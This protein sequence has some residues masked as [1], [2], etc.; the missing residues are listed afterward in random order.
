MK[1]TLKI[2]LSI[3]SILNMVYYFTFWFPEKYTWLIPTMDAYHFQLISLALLTTVQLIILIK[4]L[5]SFKYIEKSTKHNWTGLLVVFTSVSSLIFIW[6]KMGELEVKNN[7]LLTE[8][9]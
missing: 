6:K 3:P 2:L 5:W 4:K 8:G 1:T 7:A 9:H